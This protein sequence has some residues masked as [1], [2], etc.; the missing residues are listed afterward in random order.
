MN[1]IDIHAHLNFPAYEADRAEVI[2]RTVE[3]GCGV[4]NI[5][6]DVKTSQEVLALAQTTPE[7]WAA[8]GVHPE[9]AETGE[10]IDWEALALLAAEPQVVAI[11]ECGLDYFQRGGGSL[12]SGIKERQ[13]ELFER[14]ITLA[15]ELG[16]PLMLH[17]RESY[18]DVLAILKLY[19]GVRAHAHFFAAPWE[20]AKKF[21][22]QGLTLSITGVITFTDQ[23]DE[24][25]KQ[26]PLNSLL[27]ET[28]APYVAPVLYRGKRNEP[29]YVAEV[30]KRIATLKNVSPETVADAMVANARRVFALDAPGVAGA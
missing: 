28:D 1:L 4:I 2:K 15:A 9:I 29:L 23:Y 14:Q 18:D 12:E 20:T 17:I 7:F 13:R 8:V 3:A 27:A 26:T 19:P 6:T 25:V 16:K 21:L 5:G 30:V 11:G 24:V 22:D 10:E